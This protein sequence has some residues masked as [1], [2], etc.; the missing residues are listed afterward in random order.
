MSCE[1]CGRTSCTR[2][3]HSF[4]EQDTYDEV[5]DRAK[6]WM[7]HKIISRIEQMNGDGE[8]IKRSDAI[9][10]IKEV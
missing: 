1:I 8:L 9:N 4:E 2:S 5:A 6:E 7:R 10:I 3:F